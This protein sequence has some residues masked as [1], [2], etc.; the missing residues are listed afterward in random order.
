MSLD[1]PLDPLPSCLGHPL[2][3]VENAI[4]LI[5]F[6]V[7]MA[8]LQLRSRK[9]AYASFLL[10][11]LAEVLT[12]SALANLIGGNGFAAALLSMLASLAIF[13][14][15][16]LASR[17]LSLRGALRPERASFARPPPQPA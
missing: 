8:A 12:G 13:W 17:V 4:F 11:G 14:T 10:A 3:D 9:F 16:P 7:S 15:L 2:L 6:A 1:R 5:G